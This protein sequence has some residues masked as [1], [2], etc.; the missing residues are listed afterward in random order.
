MKRQKNVTEKVTVAV[1]SANITVNDLS[2]CSMEIL[3]NALLHTTDEY[4]QSFSFCAEIRP[5]Y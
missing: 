3:P 4:Q 1:A 2:F 5:G